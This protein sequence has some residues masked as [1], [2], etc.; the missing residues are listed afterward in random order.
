MNKIKDF[1]SKYILHIELFIII[2]LLIT[3]VYMLTEIFRIM[4]YMWV[5]W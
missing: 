1:I 2:I 5:A 3:V 4:C